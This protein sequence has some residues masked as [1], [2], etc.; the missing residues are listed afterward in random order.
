MADEGAQPVGRGLG[1]IAVE[2]DDAAG[3]SGSGTHRGGVIFVLENA[4]L[5]VGKVGKT[6]QLL[7]CDDHANFLRKH[8]KDPAEYRPDISHQ[9]RRRH[10]GRKTPLDFA[11]DATGVA[12]GTNSTNLNGLTQTSSRICDPQALLAVLDSPLNKAGYIRAVYV[13]TKKN[14]LFEVDPSVRIPRTFK[15]FSGLMSQLLQKLSIR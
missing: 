10:R 2:D 9:V 4:S 13:R 12:L 5:E 11:T 7:N 3:A 14:V 15:R 1:G 8:K 6:F